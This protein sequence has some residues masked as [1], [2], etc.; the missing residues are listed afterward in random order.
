MLIKICG[1]KFPKD[2]RVCEEIGADFLG[3]IFHPGSSRYV[4]PETVSAL[5][6]T[7]A[8]KVGVFVKQAV[9]EVKEIMQQAKLDMA[10]LHG[11]Y[12]PADCENIGKDRTIKVFWPERYSDKNS[13]DRE[14]KRYSEYCRYFLFDAGIKGGGHGTCIQSEFLREMKFDNPWFLAGGLN[15]EN[16]KTLIEQYAPQGIDLN[17]GVEKSPGEKDEAKLRQIKFE[18]LSS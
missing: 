17:S 16:L 8:N 5:P 3:F 2:I 18:Q 12:S 13:F 9:G 4:D 11:D 6:E 10:Q 7:R 15:P 14:L 1:L